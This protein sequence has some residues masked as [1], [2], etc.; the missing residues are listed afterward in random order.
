MSVEPEELSGTEQ[1]VLLVLMA[2]ARPVR[3]PDLAKLGPTLDKSGRDR[4]VHKGLIEVTTGKRAM[5]IELTDR[6]WATC[7][8]LIGADVPPRVTGPGKALYTVLKGLRRYFDREDLAPSSVFYAMD[9]AAPEGAAEALDVQSRV[10][11]AY[12]NLAAREGGWVDLIRLR[13]ALPDVSRAALDD[14]LTRLYRQPDVSIVPQEN[15]QSLTPADR[16][17]AVNIGDQDKH[18]IMI[19]S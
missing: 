7:G 11:A 1:A 6:G 10:R 9:E 8:R 12:V 15:Q 4:L 13:D 18:R 2:Q 3:N 19:E 17:A 5:E 14:A 16:A